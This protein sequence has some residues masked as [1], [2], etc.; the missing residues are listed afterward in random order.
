MAGAVAIAKWLSD[1]Y[2]PAFWYDW[3]LSLPVWLTPTFAL[4]AVSRTYITIWSRARMRDVLILFLTLRAG[5]A[6]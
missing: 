4:L 3:F 5:V 1:E 2:T 6:H